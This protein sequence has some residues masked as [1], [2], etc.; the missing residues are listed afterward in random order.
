MS[1]RAPIVLTRADRDRLVQ[2]I[3]VFRARGDGAL[4]A[5]LLEELSRARVVAPEEMPRD[6]VTMRSRVR[7][8]D[9]ASG[10]VLTATL[11]YPGDEDPVLGRISI[12]SPQG[13]AMIG[14]RKGDGIRW[15][16][17]DGETRALTVLEVIYQ[18]EA[19]GRFDL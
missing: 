14:L 17:L 13:S 19:A 3:D 9:E 8:R 12:L 7:Y 18:P 4:V 15:P 11:V 2:V 16:I 10:E 6:I 1:A 5:F